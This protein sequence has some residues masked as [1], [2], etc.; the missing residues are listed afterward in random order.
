MISVSSTRTRRSFSTGLLSRTSSPSLY[1]Y[2]RLLWCKCKTLLFAIL[3]F[4]WA[5]L[6][7]LLRSLWMASLYSNM[8]TSDCQV[9]YKTWN[10][11]WQRFEMTNAKW[12]FP[13][14]LRNAS[15]YT[16]LLLIQGLVCDI[17][18]WSLKRKDYGY[19]DTRSLCYLFQKQQY[20]FQLFVIKAVCS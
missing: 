13:Q 5:H 9:T 15:L 12:H 20:L 19:L 6:S 14:P 2:L 4:T 7:N 3:R 10:K 16:D 8:S 18:G 17:C 1:M 11:T